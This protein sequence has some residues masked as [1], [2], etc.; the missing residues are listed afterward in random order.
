MRNLNFIIFLGFFVALVPFLG[1]PPMWRNY[2]CVIL[3]LLIVL[4]VFSYKK[5]FYTKI[6]N[7]RKEKQISEVNKENIEEQRV[8][9][10]FNTDG[11]DE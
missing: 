3:G 9:E 7:K 11:E 6:L 4:G 1:L 2:L 5:D 10:S 8:E